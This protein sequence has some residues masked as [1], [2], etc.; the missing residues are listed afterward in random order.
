[1]QLL[2]FRPNHRAILSTPI[3]L[4]AWRHHY[5]IRDGFSPWRYVSTTPYYYGFCAFSGNC[6]L[7]LSPTP[8]PRHLLNILPLLHR[9]N[10]P[11]ASNRLQTNT[12]ISKITFSPICREH[13]SF[14]LVKH[15][16]CAS[17]PWKSPGHSNIYWR[18]LQNQPTRHFLGSCLLVWPTTFSRKTRITPVGSGKRWRGL[19]VRISLLFPVL[20]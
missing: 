16:L 13:H 4:L 8:P 2:K 11:T 12:A 3:F 19:K 1:M 9:H 15:A 17:Q 7:L 18:R 5:I 20:F 10:R 14:C 6:V